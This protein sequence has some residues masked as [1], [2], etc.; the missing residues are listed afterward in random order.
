MEKEIS[1]KE[2]EKLD[3]ETELDEEWLSEHFDELAREHPGEHAAVIDQKPVAFG[4]DFSEAYNKA[5]RKF[6]DRAP[7]MT[8][9]PKKGDELLLV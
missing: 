9:I 5:K 8:Y 7:L 3:K 4:R 2:L 1:E 6:P